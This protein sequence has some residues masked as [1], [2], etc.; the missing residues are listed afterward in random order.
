[1][2]S[3]IS[4]RS[5]FRCNHPARAMHDTFYLRSRQ[6]LLRTHTSPV[7]IRAM[8]AHGAADPGD[9]AGPRLSARFRPHS[10][11]DVSLRS[12]A[13]HRP[14]NVSFANL[15]ALS[16]IRVEVLR[17]GARLR[18]RPSYFPFT[19]PSAE[20]DIECVLCSG[21]LQRVRAERLARNPG[22]RHGSSERAAKAGI[23][24]AK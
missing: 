24:P 10:H 12:K 17:A 19:E 9:R 23:D 5:T 20:V 21:R 22:L 4:K 7:Q 8:Q 13:R 15:K 1:M 16:T 6:L 11:A 3:T 2:T 14:Q 18:F